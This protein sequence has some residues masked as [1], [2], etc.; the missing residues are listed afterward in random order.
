MQA[1][2]NGSVKDRSGTYAVVFQRKAK[3]LRF[4]GPVDCDPS[5]LQSYHAEPT[6]ILVTHYFLKYL[7]TYCQTSVTAEVTTHVDN[8]LTVDMNNLM[9]LYPGTPG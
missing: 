5:L 6:G 4:Q 8:I 1:V 7:S 2:L 3:A 9:A